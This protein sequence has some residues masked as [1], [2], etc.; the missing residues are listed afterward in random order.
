MTSRF[1]PFAFVELVSPYNKKNIKRW[2]EDINCM[3]SWQEQY[4]TSLLRSLVTY[5][6]FHSN[7]KFISSHHRVISS[8]YTLENSVHSLQS[9]FYRRSAVYILPPTFMT[10]HIKQRPYQ[11]YLLKKT[12]YIPLLSSHTQARSLIWLCVKADV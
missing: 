7:I 2:L 12:G 11:K 4:L 5:C 10:M 3:F 9:A 8:I 1:P 6:S